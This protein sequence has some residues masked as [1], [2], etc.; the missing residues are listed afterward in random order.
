MSHWLLVVQHIAHAAVMRRAAR[1]RIRCECSLNLFYYSL[2]FKICRMKI[3]CFDAY[4]NVFRFVYTCTFYELLLLVILSMLHNSP[5]RLN[6]RQ[7]RCNLLAVSSAVVSNSLLEALQLASL[8]AATYAGFCLLF[9]A[10]PDLRVCKL[11]YFALC[12]CILLL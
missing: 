12:Y 3:C 4:S 11:L 10:C 2:K 5:R 1:Q 8:T 7:R 6:Q 9:F